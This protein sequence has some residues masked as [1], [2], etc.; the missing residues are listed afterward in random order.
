MATNSQVS[1][2]S[3]RIS[4]VIPVF[5]GERFLAE[6]IQFGSFTDVITL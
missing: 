4:V 5:N 3:P 1:C 6:A 2:E